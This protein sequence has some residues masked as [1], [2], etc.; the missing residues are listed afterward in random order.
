MEEQKYRSWVEVD[1]DSFSRNWEELKR[2]V[3]PDVRIMQVVK[4]DAYGHGALELSSVALRNG[5]WALGVANADEGVQLRASGITSPV[6]ILSPS[7][8]SEIGQ[9]VKYGLTPSVSD[10]SFARELQ[11]SARKAGIRVSVHIEVDTGMGRGGTIHYE[12]LDLIRTVLDM[13]NLDLEGIFTHLSSSEILVDY[14]NRQWTHFRDLLAKLDE[15]GIR[16]PLKHMSNS[17]AVLNFPE[18]NLDL[19]R[20]GIMTYGI[21]PGPDTKDK[22]DL[23]PVMSFKTRVVL[24]K[25]FPEGY[26]IGY[27]RTYIT[28]RPTRIATIPVGYG[29]GYGIMLS[30]AGEVL[31]RGRRAPIVG[32]ISMDM[33]TVDVSRIPDCGIG[34]EVVLMGRQGAEYISANEIAARTN[35]ISYD[36]LCALGKR[37]PRVFVQKGR[38]DAVEPRL[39][40]IYIPGEEKSV[41]RIDSI[42]RHCFQTRAQSEE[43]GDAIF[44]EMFETLFG[45]EDRQLELRDRFR[46]DIEVSEASPENG[47]RK[48]GEFFRVLTRV[49]YTKALREPVF[50]IGCAMNNEQLEALFEEKRCEYRWLLNLGDEAVTERD[51]R[52]ERVTIDGED[53]PILR[54]ENTPRGFEVWCGGD[55]LK[56]KLNR[57]VRF[58]FEIATKKSKKNNLFSV[59][60]AYPTRGL[61]IS[62]NYEKANLRRVRE[63]SYF[64]GKHPYPRVAREQGKATTLTIADDEWIFPNSGVTFIWDS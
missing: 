5:A 45:K 54:A 34:D 3:G 9:I 26:S 39:R 49:E 52:I 13:P 33:C 22:A 60:V 58:A 27:N 1:L 63:V 11:R 40:R 15:N 42:I 12:A 8:D 29:D 51:F 56:K 53:V 55:L 19:V 14:N 61:Q 44:S 46:Y 16:I 10:A 30:N 6:V 24:L 20:P 64:A 31:I 37:A 48:R 32:R 28:Y 59:F 17:G 47:K 41:A 25:E 57:P 43:M 21:Y 35:T 50:M 36:V 62:F 23:S 38:A 2:L 4:A 18:Y 7:P